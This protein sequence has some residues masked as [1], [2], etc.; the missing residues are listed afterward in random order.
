MVPFE[1][2]KE[3]LIGNNEP[4]VKNR[5]SFEEKIENLIWNNDP[6]VKNMENLSKSLDEGEKDK[7]EG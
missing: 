3:N 5:I 2:K 7:N 6:F 4:L 1:E